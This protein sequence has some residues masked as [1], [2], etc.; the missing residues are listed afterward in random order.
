VGWSTVNHPKPFGSQSNTAS[1][2]IVTSS[3]TPAFSVTPRKKNR[4]TANSRIAVIFVF[5]FGP[6]YQAK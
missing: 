4:D 5:E 1:K 3:V 6:N 2:A